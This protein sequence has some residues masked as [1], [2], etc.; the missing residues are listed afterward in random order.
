MFEFGNITE[1]LIDSLGCLSLPIYFGTFHPEYIMPDLFDYGIIDGFKFKNC[2]E[3]TN[4]LKNMSEQEY[5]KRILNIKKARYK[6]YYIFSQKNIIDFISDKI[7]KII[8]KNY[9]FNNYLNDINEKYINDVKNNLF[10]NNKKIE[11]NLN[12]KFRCNKCNIGFNRSYKYIN[13]K[14][15]CY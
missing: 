3:L 12:L 5:E 9:K 11:F 15:I 6:Y 13:H 7:N 8:Y 10:P 1:K 2:Q 14:K 4:Y